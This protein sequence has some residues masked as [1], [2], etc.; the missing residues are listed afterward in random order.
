MADCDKADPVGE[1]E[2]R[3][4]GAGS[5]FHTTHW[6]VVVTAAR[7]DAPEAAAALEKLCRTY[8]YP[9]YCF[10]QRQGHRPPDAEDLTQQFF[11]G[12]LARNSFRTADPN[13]GRLRS[14]LLASFRHFLVN[15]YQRGQTV[16]R[17][18]RVDFVSLD[19]LDAPL[20]SQTQPA[21]QPASAERGFDRAWALTLLNRAMK[22]LEQSYALAG[23]GRIFEALQGYL[24]DQSPQLTYAEI[25][26]RL[27]MSESALKM[28]VL[29]LRQ[30]Y[31]KMLRREVANTLGDPTLVEDELR[32]LVESL[33]G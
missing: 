7:L 4:A 17:G 12:F 28:A 33:S 26:Q 18:G 6:S 14:F 16:K 15:E 1:S 27:E 25:G 29:R 5:A 30:Q 2:G 10:C 24:T 11:A 9:L 32:H 8:W 23:K 22:E 19:A 21:S 3:E 20:I 31:G 13:R